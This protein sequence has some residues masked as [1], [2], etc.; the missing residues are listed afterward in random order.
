M[1]KQGDSNWKKEPEYYGVLSDAKE[2]NLDDSVSPEGDAQAERSTEKRL[3]ESARNAVR[4]KES[5]TNVPSDSVFEAAQ[6]E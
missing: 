6:T 1:A 5:I 2:L 3:L 4:H